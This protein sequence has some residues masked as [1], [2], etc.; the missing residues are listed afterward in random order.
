VISMTGVE[1]EQVIKLNRKVQ[2]INRS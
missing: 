1:K 2:I